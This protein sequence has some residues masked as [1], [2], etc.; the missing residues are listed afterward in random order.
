M[1][2]TIHAANLQ[3]L[4]AGVEVVMEA[5]A[6]GLQAKVG[7][8]HAGDILQW[9]NGGDVQLGRA[10]GF[11]KVRAQSTGEDEYIAFVHP[12][13][14]VSETQWATNEAVCLAVLAVAIV[15]PVPHIAEGVNFV[16]LLHPRD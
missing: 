3:M 5:W 11:G 9:E 14:A 12:C 4:L 2:A 16:P 6:L 10:V 7:Y 13:R 8:L 1:A 15:G